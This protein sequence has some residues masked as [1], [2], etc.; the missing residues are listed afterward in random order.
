M[1]TYQAIIYGI[2]HGF[3]E[4]LPIDAQ[5]HAWAVPEVVGWSA[6][7]PVLLGGLTAGALLAVLVYFRHDWFSMISCGLQVF[8]YRK[9]PMT[10]DERM[11]FFVILASIP[12]AIAWFYGHEFV[13]S[14]ELTWLRV[15][16]LLALFALPLAFSDYW[17]RKNKRLP[18]WNWIDA[19]FVGVLQC[20]F[21]VP[22]CGRMTAALT[23]ACLRNYDREASAK[24]AFF[25]SAPILAGLTLLHLKGLDFHA[26]APTEG[27]TWL[28]FSMACLVAFLTG[29]L[30]IGG[31][32][33]KVLVKSYGRYAIYRWV[34]AGGLALTFWLRN[35]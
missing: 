17:S 15:A 14:F 35:R 34:A 10:M 16:G 9:K 5:A 3:S 23:A 26:A 31:F 12:P 19:L 25:A 33:K 24:F 27:L 22:G 30:A 29:L 1:D 28:A 13:E 7:P 2:I 4:F 8:V 18:D 21:F 6:A 11:P 20:C 32:M